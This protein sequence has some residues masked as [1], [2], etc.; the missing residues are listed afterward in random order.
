MPTSDITDHNL[1]GR[2]LYEVRQALHIKDGPEPYEDRRARANQERLKTLSE[3][4]QEL[5]ARGMIRYIEGRW[6]LTDHAFTGHGECHPCWLLKLR[7]HYG[8]PIER[9]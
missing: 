5:E 8:I 4:R 7:L 3:L 6:D 1:L 2:Y 9:L